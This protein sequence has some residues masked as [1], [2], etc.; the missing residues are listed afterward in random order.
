MAKKQ[1]VLQ[2]DDYSCGPIAI[3]NAYIWKYGKFTSKI[4][5]RK[6]RNLC[7]TNAKRGT[8]R[9]NMKI[10]VLKESNKPIYAIKNIKKSL[11]NYNGIILDYSFKSV[12]NN[13][14]CHYVFIYKDGCNY[15]VINGL[16]EINGKLEYK[17]VKY[18]SWNSLYNKI[19]RFNPKDELGLDYPCAWIIKK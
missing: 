11:E 7:K 12:Q 9:W 4:S 16:K 18:N 19:L 13:I 6:L 1:Y 14:N 2:R 15:M 10:D 3:L 17:N 8:E 5:F